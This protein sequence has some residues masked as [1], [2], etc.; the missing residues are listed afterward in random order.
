MGSRGASSGATSV[1]PPSNVK[2]F[3]GT[4]TNDS[5]F[6]EVAKVSNKYMLID[7]VQDRDNAIIMTSDVKVVKG[8]MIMMTGENTA[9]YLKPWQ[10]RLMENYDL[11]V[12]TFAV[13]LSRKYFKEYTFKSSFDD[14]GGERETFDSLWKT[15]AAQQRRKTKWKVGKRVI[16]SNN[17]WY[18]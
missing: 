16:I 18:T 15:A 14:Y 13:K 17:S 12:Q 6:G 1:I 7:Q 4:K 3:K 8:N 11:G 2:D 5:F 9:I 10:F